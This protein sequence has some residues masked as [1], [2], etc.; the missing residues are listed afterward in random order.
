MMIKWRDILAALQNDTLDDIERE[1]LVAL[2]AAR[3]AYD[4]GPAGRRPTAQDVMTVAREEFAVFIGAGQAR[5]A[6]SRG[7]TGVGSA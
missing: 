3:L 1:E 6:L 4:R 7:Q 5:A 2:A